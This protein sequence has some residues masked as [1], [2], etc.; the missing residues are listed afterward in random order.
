M[1]SD[2][3]LDCATPTAHGAT[4]VAYGATPTA[5]G[6]TP[7]ATQ[8]GFGD[9]RGMWSNQQGS[10]EQEMSGRVFTQVNTFRAQH[11]MPHLHWSPELAQIATLHAQRM[12]RGE[13]SFDHQNFDQRVQAIPF[14]HK[15]VAENL[16]MNNGSGQGT[17]PVDKAVQ[18]WINSSGHCKNLLGTF[19]LTGVGI[20]CSASGI[21]YFNQLYVQA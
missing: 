19:T 3:G 9:F 2:F 6:A 4:P 14:G 1:Q 13:A 21:F 15:G 11:M 10:M 12:A 8:P 7:R 5:Y 17:D 20:A 18:G 16:G